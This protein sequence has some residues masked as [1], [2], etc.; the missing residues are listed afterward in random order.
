MACCLACNNAKG[1][2]TLAQLGWS[3]KVSPTQ[4]RGAQWR[5]R[6]LERPAEQ[7]MQFLAHAA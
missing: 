6:E 3:L 7:W 1:D 5:I 2:R 4:P